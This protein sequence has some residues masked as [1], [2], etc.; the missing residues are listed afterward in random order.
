MTDRPPSDAD[1]PGEMLL[2]GYFV[3]VPE[4]LKLS[5]LP[6]TERLISASD[7]LI[8]R[9]PG[10]GCWFG[11][12][13]EALAACRPLRLPAE[14]RM[15]ALP[16]PSEHVGGFVA[17]IRAAGTDE[18]VLLAHL[19]GQDAGEA[20]REV[21]EDGHKLGWEVLGTTTACS[22]PGSATVCTR[23]AGSTSEWIL[24]NAVCCPTG[25]PPYDSPPGRTLVETPS[26]SPGS[27]AP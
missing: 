27:L 7:C 11:T 22:T 3:A 19:D 5:G 21:A 4:E 15:Y 20:A 10:E 9:L 2:A 1:V 6:R 13:Q 26:R 8:D 24:M 16:V 14:A 18:P 25:R 12:V 17:D 23:R